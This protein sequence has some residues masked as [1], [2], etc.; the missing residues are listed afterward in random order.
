MAKKLSEIG[1]L[2]SQL[3]Q[4]TK[5]LKYVESRTTIINAAAVKLANGIQLLARSSGDNRDLK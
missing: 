4:I 1:R 5:K 2:E 3:A